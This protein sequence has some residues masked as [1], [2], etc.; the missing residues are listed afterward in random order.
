MTRRLE[1]SARDYAIAC[2][3]RRRDDSLIG[4]LRPLRLADVYEDAKIETWHAHEE[5]LASH[6][7]RLVRARVALYLRLLRRVEAWDRSGR[8][9][10]THWANFTRVHPKSGPVYCV[11]AVRI[12]DSVREINGPLPATTWRPLWTLAPAHRPGVTAR[13]RRKEK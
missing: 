7:T 6:V 4:A 3:S 9:S 10:F 13:M 12:G 11:E 2:C 8:F 5:W 1:S